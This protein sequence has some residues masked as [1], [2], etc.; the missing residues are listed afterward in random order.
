MLTGQCDQAVELLHAIHSMGVSA[1]AEH[2]FD[3][4]EALRDYATLNS[5]QPNGQRNDYLG[6]VSRSLRE[7]K[8]AWRSDASAHGSFLLLIAELSDPWRHR[9]RDELQSAMSEFRAEH[10]KDAPMLLD[11]LEAFAQAGRL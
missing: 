6:I 7:A 2:E 4:E 8:Q 10:G 11:V 9:H 3:L 1:V 5:R